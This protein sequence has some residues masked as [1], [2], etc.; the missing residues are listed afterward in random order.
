M[1][2]YN[3]MGLLAQLE[4]DGCGDNRTITIVLIHV[5]MNIPSSWIWNPLEGTEGR[6]PLGS[7]LAGSSP[8]AVARHAPTRGA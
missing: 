5:L 8:M 7:S 1:T 6:G 4:H 3:V 2:F